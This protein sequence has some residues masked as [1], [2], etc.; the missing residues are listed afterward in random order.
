MIGADS[1]VLAFQQ[2]SDPLDPAG[3]TIHFG[4]R[5]GISQPR[6]AGF[7]EADPEQDDRPSVE[8]WNFIIEPTQGGGSATQS[9]PTYSAHPLLANGCFAAFRMLYQ[10]VETFEA[11]ISQQGATPEQAELVAAK[12]C[13]RWRD[14][15]PLEI[16]PERPRSQQLLGAS[17]KGQYH[18]NNFDYVGTSVHQQPKPAPFGNPDLGQAC[19]YAAH[20]RR[21]NPRDDSSV[22]GNS[23]GSQPLMA[24]QHRILRR[25]RPYGPAYD[26]TEPGSG[27]R[28]RGLIGLFLGADLGNQF[29]FL[30]QTWITQGS[31]SQNDDSPNDSGYDP[32]FGPPPLAQSE[33]TTEFSY[34]AGN[35]GDPSKPA[36]YAVL[37]GLPQL[38]VTV[39]AL[40][41]FLPGIPA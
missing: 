21:A 19:P 16:S 38:V 9:T 13:G 1:A 18:L 30:M 17:L 23:D 37:P 14:G 4:Y 36:D 33:D 27:S 22:L 29:E 28:P 26:P 24:A 8:A 7:S 2:D 31:F 39:G 35:P 32:L 25:A 41:V 15:T 6:I 10:D 5:D 3:Q 40:Y 12:M 34:C 11:F 20:V